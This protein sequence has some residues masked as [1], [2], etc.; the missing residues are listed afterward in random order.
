MTIYWRI[1]NFVVGIYLLFQMALW[2]ACQFPVNTEDIQTTSQKLLDIHFHQH[3]PNYYQSVTEVPITFV[4]EPTI[5]QHLESSLPG[6]LVSILDSITISDP[7]QPQRLN[8]TDQKDL[9]AHQHE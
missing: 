4:T 6:V 1:R 7:L 3:L 9:L 2:L 8:M 5:S